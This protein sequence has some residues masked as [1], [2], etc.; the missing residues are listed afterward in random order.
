MASSNQP[1]KG[2]PNSCHAFID[3]QNINLG[4]RQLGW[5]LDWQRFRRYLQEKHGVQQAFLFIGFLAENKKLYASLQQ[6]GFVLVF[7][8][9]YADHNGKVK[10]NVDAELIMEAMTTLADYD[11][12]LI[13][14]GDG[15]FGVLVRYLADNKKLAGVL[16]PNRRY[17]SSILRRAAGKQM[18]FMDD[19]KL[20]LAYK[21]KRTP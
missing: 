15:D 21:K 17:C 18:Y 16:A 6:A 20:K 9:T 19:L 10:G 4:I 13:V 8:E 1:P 11:R 12:A 3:A 7:K 5:S 14:S 2:P